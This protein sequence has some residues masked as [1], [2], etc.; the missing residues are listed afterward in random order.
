MKYVKLV[1]ETNQIN[2]KV[3][4]QKV[5]DTVKGQSLM[6]MRKSLE[7]IFNKKNI[8]FVTSPVAHF[9]I[10]DGGKT[11]IIVNKKYAD[12]ADAIDGDLAFGWEGQI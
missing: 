3:D 1:E 7:T 4:V 6:S 10:K 12:K 5:V 9:R 11:F 8:D 2:E